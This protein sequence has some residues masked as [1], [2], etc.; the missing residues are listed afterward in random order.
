MLCMNVKSGRR[1]QRVLYGAWLVLV[2]LQAVWL[3]ILYSGWLV[4]SG[5]LAGYIELIGTS[6]EKPDITY[7]VPDVIAHPLGIG[8]AVIMIVLTVVILARAPKTAGQVT[9]QA[10][11]K[12][13]KVIEPVVR[14]ALPRRS[15]MRRPWHV[16]V[17]A[18]M[19]ISVLIFIATIPIH[20]VT[21]GISPVVLWTVSSSL[22]A[23]ALVL[24]AGA[25]VVRRLSGQ[26]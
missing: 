3:L 18:Q 5:R 8:I 15:V 20:S 13:A 21:D 23:I 16:H 12:A 11:A 22:A 2:A 1:V 25:L 26:S 10:T 4:N 19:V 7:E 17:I 14:R 9:I 24:L 6:A